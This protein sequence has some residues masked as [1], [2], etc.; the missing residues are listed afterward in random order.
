M[1]G[2]TVRIPAQV[3]RVV[4][5]MYPIATQLMLLIGKPDKLVGISSMDINPVMKRIYPP[6]E[7]IYRPGQSTQGDISTEEIIKMNPDVVFTHMRNAFSNNLDGTGIA[8]VCLKLE[9]PEQLMDGILLVGEIM[10]ARKRAEQVVGYY[11]EKLDY[12]ESRTSS[13]QNKKHVYFAGPAMLS[14]AGHDLYQNFVIEY[15]GG[16]N[17]ARQAKGGWCTISI[18]HL[19]QWNPDF[20]FIGNYGTAH[21]ESFTRDSRLQGITAVQSGHVY[22]SPHYIGSW[23]IPTPESLLCI[24]WLANKL[25]PEKIG[26]DMAKEMREF[27]STCYGYTPDAQEIY[28]VLGEQ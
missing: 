20:I 18:E 12:I 1:A 11:R 5:S 3:N 24:M 4:T 10:N 27:Y 2:N 28:H 16:I 25:Y 22:M 14:T 6:I 7:T 26:F 21:V 13:I 19:I 17:A 23:D 15:A 8:S 9:T